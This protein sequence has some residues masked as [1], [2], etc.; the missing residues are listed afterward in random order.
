M[1]LAGSV[2]S[3]SAICQPSPTIPIEETLASSSAFISPVELAR[4]GTKAACLMVQSVCQGAAETAMTKAN[5]ITF[6][7]LGN[8]S[9][10]RKTTLKFQVTGLWSNPFAKAQLETLLP[11]LA[12]EGW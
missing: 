8:Q 2:V 12:N 7:R 5:H 1:Y 3:L 11:W 6:I 10:K 9:K 4:K